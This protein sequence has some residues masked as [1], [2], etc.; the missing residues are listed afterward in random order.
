M[1]NNVLWIE[2]CNVSSVNKKKKKNCIIYEIT[3]PLCALSLI[4]R[5]V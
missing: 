2:Y 3:E 1:F 4:D 5:C